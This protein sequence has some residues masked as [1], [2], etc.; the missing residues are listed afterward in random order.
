MSQSHEQDEA[1]KQ[2][3]RSRASLLSYHS[4]ECSICRHPER[5]LIDQE[6]VQWAPAASIAIAHRIQRRAI[7]RHAH[8]TDLFQR[9][10][11]D[12]SFALG[13]IIEHAQTV[14][15]TA[16][17]IIRAVRLFACLNDEGEWIGPPMR[18]PAVRSA[19]RAPSVSRGVE[20]AAS[21]PADSPRP[22]DDANRDCGSASA[23]PASCPEPVVVRSTHPID[24]NT[25]QVIEN[26]LRQSGQ[27]DT[28]SHP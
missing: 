6:F 20:A 19:R 25:S 26:N 21:H 10:N 5:D 18:S 15:V 27:I 8:A 28:D 2:P 17:S 24:Q 1:P 9:R 14:P 4:R 12:L 23:A 13:R 16:D 7:Y 3:R 22:P 11:R